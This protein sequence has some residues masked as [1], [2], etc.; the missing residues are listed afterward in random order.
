MLNWKWLCRL[1]IS[2]CSW[3]VL[4]KLGVL[5][6]RCSWIILCVGLNS[7]VMWLVLCSMWVM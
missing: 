1:L 3:I 2:V 5:L 7:G 4:R 6:F